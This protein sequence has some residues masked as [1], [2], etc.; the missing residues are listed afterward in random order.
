MDYC[1][2]NYSALRRSELSSA[3]WMG[4][5]EA[6]HLVV[7]N[8]HLDVKGGIF[9]MGKEMGIEDAMALQLYEVRTRAARCVGYMR[10]AEL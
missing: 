4:R 9:R 7:Q 2:P 6:S 1:P 5:P 10:Y 8:K 3:R